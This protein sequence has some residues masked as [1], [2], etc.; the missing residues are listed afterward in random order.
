MLKL[1]TDS[2]RRIEE[3]SIS[4]GKLSFLEIAQDTIYLDIKDVELGDSEIHEELVLSVRFA[5]NS[6]INFFYN[7]IWSLEFLANFDLKNYR[8]ETTVD[9]KINSIKFLDFEYLEQLKEKFSKDKI[10]SLYK[11]FDLENLRCDFFLL[12]EFDELAMVVGA[13]QM[14]FFSQSEKL[15]D[16]TLKELSNQWVRYFLRYQSKRNIINK[17]SICENTSLK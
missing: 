5:N 8:L 13:N 17:D 1:N 2:L 14:Y 4:S 9:F 10:I 16:Y 11:D 12:L 15:D 7:D 6:F 3:V